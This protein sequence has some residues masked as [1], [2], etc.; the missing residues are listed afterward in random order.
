MLSKLRNIT[1]GHPE[2]MIKPILWS[3]LSSLIHML[4]FGCMAFVVGTIYVYY[5]EKQTT[6]NMQHL[7]LAW[8]GMAVCFILLFVCERIS[9]RSIYRGAYEA[10]AEGRT[11]LA[12]HIR[13]LPIGFLMRKDPGE[14]GHTMMNDFTQ[15]ENA[16]TNTLPQ[17][18]SGIIIPILG[19]VGL[20]FIDWRMSVAMIAGFPISLLILSAVSRLERKLG[21]SHSKAKIVQANCLQEY[22]FGMKIIKA[23]NL[24][25]ENFKRLEQSFYHYMKESIKLEGALGPFF[26]V[27]MAFIQTGMALITIV[28]A[29]LILGGEL[30]VPLFGVFLLVGTHVFDPLTVAIM[31]LPAFKYDAMAG[32]RIVNLLQQQVMTGDNPAPSHHDIRFENVTFGYDK[33]IV[34]DQ[35][36]AE[37]KEGTLTAIVGPSGSGKSTMLR[38]IARFYDPLQGKVLIGGSDEREI[39]PEKLIKKISMVFQDVYLFQDT[40]RSNIRYGKE[41]ATQAEIEAAAKEAC[42]HDFIMKL[43]QGYDTMVGEGGST[44]SGG[45]KQRI[46][47]ARAILKDAPVILLDEATS[48]L[49]PENEVEMQKAIA[50]LVKGR[51]V[52]MIAHRLKTVVRADSIIVLDRGKVV[53]QGRHDELL[54]QDGLYAKLWTLQNKMSGWKITA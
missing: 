42:C 15:I 52:I 11:N 2:K 21:N 4:P 22:L 36:S 8:G 9:Y 3:I 33:S 24:R 46:S 5:A 6:L 29:Y 50:R 23:Y 20:L 45:E 16:A 30:N 44:L 17:L 14:L 27:A 54:Q 35:V 39:D 40:I 43:P 10:S 26:L 25:G 37:M 32:E 51:T 19:F 13:K 41:D 34:L 31:R 18:V 28:G 1:A 48:S 47:I 7:W 49:D 12:E 53:E 38:L